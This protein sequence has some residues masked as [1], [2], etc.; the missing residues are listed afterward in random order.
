MTM[1]VVYDDAG[2]PIASSARLDGS[3]PR[4]P[5]GVFD[6]GRA[7]REERVT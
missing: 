1:L 6:F 7:N 3:T 4:P 5:K 2:R